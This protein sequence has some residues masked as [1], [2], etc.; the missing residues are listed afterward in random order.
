MN[1]LFMHSSDLTLAVD[2]H[3]AKRFLAV[4]TFSG[5]AVR[6][7]EMP[8]DCVKTVGLSACFIAQTKD[9]VFIPSSH[10]QHSVSYVTFVRAQITRPLRICTTQQAMQ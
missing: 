2:T 8:G 4:L 9:S 7:G 1:I 10:L 5:T 3:A 6:R